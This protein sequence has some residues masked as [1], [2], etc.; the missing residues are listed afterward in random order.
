M[1]QLL[2]S[3]VAALLMH[4]VRSQAVPW[5]LA[6][7]ARGSAGLGPVPGLR[8]AKVLGSGVDGGF[9][10][11]PGWDCQ[12]VFG[13]FDDLEQAQ[14][15]AFHSPLAASYANH[16]VE[17]FALTLLVTSARGSWDGER[18]YAR[19]SVAPSGGPVAA[20]TRASIRPSRMVRFWKHS[21]ASEESL[22][23]AA[24]CRVAIGLGEAPLLRQATFSLWES[25]PAMDAYARHGA[26][27]TAIA[28]ARSGDMFSESLFARF[29][30]IDVRGTWNGRPV[31][32]PG[33]E[34]AR[35]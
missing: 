24:G 4:R 17:G 22:Q 13:V 12:G 3:G 18:L 34:C 21:P 11:R 19:A 6:K 9:G 26:H 20:L 5:L 23:R 15:F 7:L 32:A 8:F 2:P 25:Q 33:E 31:G 16:A 1:G 35:V 30:P 10:L 29:L 14:A 27:Q 28:D